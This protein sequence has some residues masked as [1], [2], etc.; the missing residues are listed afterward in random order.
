MNRPS[1]FASFLALLLLAAAFVIVSSISLPSVVA[2]HFAGGGA[3]N[4]FMPRGAYIAVMLSATVGLPLLLLFLSSLIRRVPPQFINLPN[5]DYWLAPER[6]A[7]TFAFLQLHGASFGVLLAIFLCFA[8][9]LVVRA[10]AEHPPLFPESLFL[11]GL[12]LFAVALVAWL[13][14]LVVH[15]RRRP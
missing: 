9:W 2:S 10:N 12:M 15:F 7:G 8:H 13:G 11:A 4:G 14:V 6:S 5:R 1:S 3:A